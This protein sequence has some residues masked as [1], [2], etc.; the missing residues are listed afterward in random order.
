LQQVIRFLNLHQEW[1]ET[2]ATGVTLVYSTSPAKISIIQHLCLRHRHSNQLGTWI[3][4]INFSVEAPMTFDRHV[5]FYVAI[6]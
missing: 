6:R 5:A 3:G 2:V 4:W 1:R